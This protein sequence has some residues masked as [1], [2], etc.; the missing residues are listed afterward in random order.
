MAPLTE[1][2][3]T[4]ISRRIRA[5]LSRK[6]T[7]GTYLDR[8]AICLASADAFEDDNSAAQAALVG[9]GDAP[10]A[11]NLYFAGDRRLGQVLGDHGHKLHAGDV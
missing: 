6:T 1:V 11:H 7:K 9:V 3:G 5:A 8:S 2:T 10:L 4:S